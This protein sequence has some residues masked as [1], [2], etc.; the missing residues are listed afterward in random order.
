MNHVGAVLHCIVRVA[1]QRLA[2]VAGGRKVA[3]VV[4]RHV[5]LGRAARMVDP[6]QDGTVD[7]PGVA[8]GQRGARRS[9]A[10][11]GA[12]A[13]AV[14]PVGQPVQRTHQVLAVDLAAVAQV[15]AQVRAVRLDDTGE[16]GVRAVQD[17]FLPHERDRQHLPAR[18]FAGEAPQEPALGIGQRAACFAHGAAKLLQADG[19]RG[20]AAACRG[21]R[22]EMARFLEGRIDHARHRGRVHG[23]APAR[24]RSPWLATCRAGVP[25]RASCAAGSCVHH[26]AMHGMAEA[27]DGDAAFDGWAPSGPAPSGTPSWT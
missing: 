9:L 25:R 4:V 7:F 18:E 3:E 16:P 27:V 22:R 1:V 19:V 12:H 6:H 11:P 24:A 20:R 5:P 15:S 26:Q 21:G 14:R 10:M 13:A 17:E 23:S 2:D 8:R